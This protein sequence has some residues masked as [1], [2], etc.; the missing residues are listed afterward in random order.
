LVDENPLGPLHEY[1]VVKGLVAVPVRV[2]VAPLHKVVDDGVAVTA[3]GAEL[4]V[5]DAVVAEVLP[6][7]LVAVRVYT[8]ED[9]VVVIIAAGLRLVD[10]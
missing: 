1:V 9:N 5:T 2:S 8:P 3:V 10:E 6:Q 7:P 4:T